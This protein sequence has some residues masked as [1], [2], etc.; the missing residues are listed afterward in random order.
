MDY[1]QAFAISATGMDIERLRLE[2]TAL[3][4][5]N[6]HSV[7]EAG[8]KPYQP[9]RVMARSSFGALMAD[10]ALARPHITLEPTGA[11]QRL[12][13]EPGHPLA[14]ARGMVA[15][16]GIDTANEMLTMMSAL[17]AYEAN[18]AALNGART[19]A[20]KALEIGGAS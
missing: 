3:N 18:V 8:A 12:V 6:T 2:V 11:A 5:A 10:G 20:Q 15:Y 1:R 4:L 14:D 19:M 7:A 9:M 17:R 16:P 13:S